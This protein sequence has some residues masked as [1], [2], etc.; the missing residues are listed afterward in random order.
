MSRPCE[1][2]RPINSKAMIDRLRWWRRGLPF[3]VAPPRLGGQARWRRSRTPRVGSNSDGQIV[4]IETVLRA[5][6]AAD[7]A[8]TDKGAAVLKDAVSVRLRDVRLGSERTARLGRT[9]P[10]ARSIRLTRSSMARV[11]TGTSPLTGSAWIGANLKHVRCEVEVTIQTGA[12][13]AGR[14]MR[15][16]GLIRGSREH[17]RVDQG[18]AA[19]TSS[20]DAQHPI[21]PAEVEEPTA[22]LPQPARLQISTVPRERPPRPTSTALQNRNPQTRLRQPGN[23][24]SSAEAATHHNGVE[25]A[26]QVHNQNPPTRPIPRDS[27]SWV[28]SLVPQL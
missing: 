22:D 7:H 17:V 27:P 1:A 26:A 19:P 13:V 2:S 23:R 28:P 8:F 10:A 3:F 14:P 5:L 6:I 24:H 21:Q 9:V 12:R 11:R 25:A 4:V 18:A 20:L 15:P 16:E